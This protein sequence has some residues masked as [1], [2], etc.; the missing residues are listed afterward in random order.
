MS[1][2]LSPVMDHLL[3][4][5]DLAGIPL[6]VTLAFRDSAGSAILLQIL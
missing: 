5:A 6:V 2:S 1:S 3:A 4:E